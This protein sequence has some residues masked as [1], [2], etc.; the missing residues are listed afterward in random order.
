MTQADCVHST[1]P[2]DTSAIDDPKSS[3]MAERFEHSPQTFVGCMGPTLVYVG[4]ADRKTFDEI[5]APCHDAG[6]NENGHVL[7]KQIGD[8]GENKVTV[9]FQ[10]WIKAR[11]LDALIADRLRERE[12]AAVSQTCPRNDNG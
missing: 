6:E 1:P 10:H 8:H 2:T 7:V 4:V 9:I 11:T 12:A 5:G 3:P